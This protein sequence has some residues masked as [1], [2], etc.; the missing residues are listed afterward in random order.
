MRRSLLV[1]LL[2][3]VPLARIIATYPVF[4]QTVDEPVHL[5]GGFDWLT[6]PGYDLDPEHPPLARVAFALD[7]WMHGA[8]IPPGIQFRDARGNALLERDPHYVRNLA[9]ARAGNLPFFLIAIAA[10]G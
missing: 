3:L 8:R 10:V 6:S 7:A 5:A 9:A 2:A 1:L 4:S